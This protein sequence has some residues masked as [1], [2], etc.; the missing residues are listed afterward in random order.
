L[1]YSAWSALLYSAVSDAFPAKGVAAG[2]AV[3]GLAAL[4]G[5]MAGPPLL[6]VVAEARGYPTVFVV[7]GATAAVGAA[8]VLLLAWFGAAKQ[9]A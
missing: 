9:T 8:I 1:G 4:I 7:A 3:G 6:G 5:G 2:A